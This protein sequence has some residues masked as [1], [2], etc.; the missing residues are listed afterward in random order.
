MG[1]HL[2]EGGTGSGKSVQRTLCMKKSICESSLT[3]TQSKRV[4]MK[5]LAEPVRATGGD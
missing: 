1:E 2:G 4:K 5:A 3:D